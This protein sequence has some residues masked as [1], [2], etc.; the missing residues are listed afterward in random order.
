[1]WDFSS[2]TL[3][4]VSE[5]GTALELFGVRRSNPASFIR[6]W[7]HFLK[8]P[9]SPCRNKSSKLLQGQSHAI[10]VDK[11]YTLTCRGKCAQE[12]NKTMAHWVAPR[13]KFGSG[14][15]YITAADV[16][17]LG[18]VFVSPGKITPLLQ[19]RSDFCEYF[20]AALLGLLLRISV[21]GS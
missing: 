17:L 2:H 6:D 4:S 11:E 8:T 3:P 13:W 16:Q 14:P 21:F 9:G 12:Q 20:S 19:V 5:T 1:M 10:H 15:G 7:Q 18:V